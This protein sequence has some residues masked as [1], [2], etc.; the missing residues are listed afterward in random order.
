MPA[1]SHNSFLRFLVLKK[2]AYTYRTISTVLYC[3][4]R[5][6]ESNE[7]IDCQGGGGV[8]LLL[9]LRSRF[10]DKPVKFQVVCPRNGTAVLK[11]LR[12]FKENPC[13]RHYFWHKTTHG[14]EKNSSAFRG[15]WPDPRVGSRGVQNVT[16]RVGSAQEVLKISRVESGRVGSRSDEK[17]TGRVRS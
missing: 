12:P 17:L 4:V 13:N 5:T 15:S 6:S 3:T 7:T 10:G 8:D 9:V 16:G 11:G 1:F 14:T 2:I